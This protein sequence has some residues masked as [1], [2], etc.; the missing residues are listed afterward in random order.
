IFSYSPPA[1][2]DSHSFAHRHRFN[3]GGSNWSQDTQLT[4]ISNVTDV[5]CFDE[6]KYSVESFDSYQASPSG[7]KL[8][9]PSS[10][11]KSSTSSESSSHNSE[12]STGGYDEP[13]FDLSTINSHLEYFACYDNPRFIPEFGTITECDE[14]IQ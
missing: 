3:R 8:G 11:K 2:K 4:N 13:H 9:S 6:R 5:N 1:L 10:S 14:K 7:S 12:L